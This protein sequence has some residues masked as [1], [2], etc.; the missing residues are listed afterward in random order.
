MK[1]NIYQILWS[2]IVMVIVTTACSNSSSDELITTNTG[3]L[4]S[5]VIQCGGSYYQRTIDQVGRVISLSGIRASS[6]ITGVSYQLIK[7]AT[8]VPDPKKISR[9]EKTQEFTVSTE[10]GTKIVYTV[11]LPDLSE[12]PEKGSKVVIGYIIANDWDMNNPSNNIRWEYLTH[13]NVSFVHVKSDGTLNTSKVQADKLAEIRTKAHEYGVKV[14]ISINKNSSG[15]FK[16]AIGSEA[17]RNTLV[18]NIVKF[19]KENQL[20][21]FDIDYEDYD[22]WDAASLVAFAKAL[23][24]AKEED[25][26]MT[27]AVVTWKDYTN[28]WQQY[29]DYI[30]IMSYD[31]Q[32]GGNN[33]TPGQHASYDKFVSDLKYWLNDQKA[34]KSKIIGGLPFYGY[35]WD[36]NISKDEIGAVR[37]NGIINHFKNQGYTIEEI[38]DTDQISKTY[39]NGRPTIR[40][41]CQ[42]VVENNF[43][44]VMIWQLFQDAEQEEYQLIKVVN[45]EM[46]K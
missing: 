27:C 20:D 22:N 37:F 32:M 23:Y 15:E 35:S 6:E 4:Q 44:G 13:V 40:K 9:W 38:A 46:R 42:Y 25:M 28:E 14:L 3:P 18:Q 24:E 12:E 31:Y 39:Y 26:L 43:G 29:F 17:T 34:P 2:M 11:N 33:T 7:G 36:N 41:K 5:F 1:R 45:E 16:A 30:N 8:I 10:D 19:T 21:G